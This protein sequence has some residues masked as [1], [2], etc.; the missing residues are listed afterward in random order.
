MSSGYTLIRAQMINSRSSPTDRRKLHDR[1]RAAKPSTVGITPINGRQIDSG[2]MD[3][4]AAIPEAYR[5]A[6]LDQC[7]R[8]RIRKGQFIWRQ[9]DPVNSVAFLVEGKTIST[10]DGLNGKTGVI[11]LW[12]PGDMLGAADIGLS[13]GRQMTVRC[14]EDCLVYLMDLDKFFEISRRFPEVA[15]TVIRALSIRLRWVSHLAVTL[16]TQTAFGRTCGVLVA[17]SECFGTANDGSVI[18]EMDLTH[19]DLASL[20]G[21][22]RQFMNQTL[23]KLRKEGLI[24]IKR[25]KI[26]VRDVQSLRTL[27][28]EE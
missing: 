21:V 15:Q 2:H 28:N 26:I 24:D 7:V 16:E 23:Q 18:I 14:L 12:L 10:Y 27:T 22:S 4:L 6:V 1:G 20:V 5:G 11:G 19:S 17:L 25:Q 3:V 13:G 8:K 9:G